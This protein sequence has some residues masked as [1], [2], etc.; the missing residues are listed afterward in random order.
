MN[1]AARD[2]ANYTKAM[3]S[4]NCLRSRVFVVSTGDLAGV[5]RLEACRT[6]GT[7]RDTE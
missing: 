7:L 2:I 1:E 5:L 6:S 3:D 4:E